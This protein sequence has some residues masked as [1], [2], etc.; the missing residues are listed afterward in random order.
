MQILR[1]AQNDMSSWALT[2]AGLPLLSRKSARPGVWAA[3]DSKRL[4]RRLSAERS[5]GSAFLRPPRRY[6]PL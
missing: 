1:S 4:T 2:A 3:V 6:S 5:E